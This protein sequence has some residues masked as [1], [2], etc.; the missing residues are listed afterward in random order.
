MNAPEL[1]GAETAHLPFV[2][3]EARRA[4]LALLG[5]VGAFES[6]PTGEWNF[7]NPQLCTML[8]VPASS[9]LGREWIKM[10]HPDDVQR[11]VAEY[12]QARDGGRSWHHEL[13]FR[14]F[15]GTLLPVLI[16]ASPLPQD[17]DARGVS[18]LGVVTD[19][20]REMRA[21]EIVEESRN[22]LQTMLDVATEG[23]WV[24]R[25]RRIVAA[26]Q[27]AAT[28]VGFDSWEELIGRD[29]LEF[30]VEEDR[31]RFAAAASGDEPTS[32]VGTL[33]RRDGTTMRVSVRATP[34]IYAGAPARLSSVVAMDSP[35]IQRM[36][37]ERLE[38]QMRAI[39]R[40]LGLP[41]NRIE[42]RG[43]R[44]VIVGANPAYAEMVGRTVDDLI[45]RDLH[46][47]LAPADNPVAF[48][49]M[50]DFTAS[51]ARRPETLPATYLRPDGT[52]VTGQV[53]SVDFT[54]PLTGTVTWLSFVVPL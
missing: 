25:N 10:I 38:L 4:T 39:E 5:S 21:Q 46:E 13:R 3:I 19:V 54:D 24:H 45:G 9:L 12:K 51:A 30:V 1:P 32:T 17:P 8:D 49:M 2:S 47:L 22:A 50:R 41:F 33:L 53:Y 43:D 7:V 11:A 15:D 18:Y 40:S 6:G 37:L 29:A 34:A 52:T 16:D 44:F 26:N 23:I 28:I 48:A 31:A 36:S 14:R 27:A 35:H 42:A 20:S